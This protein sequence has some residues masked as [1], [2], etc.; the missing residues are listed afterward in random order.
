[1]ASVTTRSPG[2]G[3]IARLS[4]AVQQAVRAAAAD[5]VER[6]TLIEAIL[7][8]AVAGE[9]LL[10]IG[11]PGTAKSQA[12]RRVAQALGGRYFEYL[13]GRFTEPGEIFGP[14]DLLKL[15]QGKVETQ[16]AGMLPEAEI[17]FLDEVFLGSTAILNTLLA[18]LNERRFRRGHSTIEVP[19]RLCVGASNAL[20]EDP[21]LAA[22]ADRFL[23]RVFVEPVPD[24]E[25]EALLRAGRTHTQQ[26]A[27][28]PR[29][30]IQDL[31]Q[32]A[33]A[34]RDVDLTGVQPAVAQAVRLL[35]RAGIALTDRRIVHAQ[36]LVA[37]AAVLAGRGAA[38]AQ[39]LWPLIFAVPTAVEQEAAREAL[40]EHL[41]DTDSVLSAAAFD[42]SA[43][44]LAR[45]R[46]IAERSSALL[47]EPPAEERAAW[48]LRVEALAREI[49][50]SFGP[51]LP[52][53]LVAVR[54][55][56][57]SVLAT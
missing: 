16:T 34:R 14:I 17:A 24:S 1:M 29:V 32:L 9:H 45:A 49:D 36:N 23:V 11:A 42:A 46:Q 30:S 38:T 40:R 8:A 51:D 44:P 39:D 7:L 28:P 47:Q 10:V 43:G 35:R 22:F 26:P 19:L 52:E 54:E 5:L 31:D 50:A 21:S 48:E 6:E 25:L 20:P 12:V 53:P 13:L 27:G 41:A 4:E 37:A 56:I 55:Q 2:D 15:Q 18:V 57:K 33:R 3:E